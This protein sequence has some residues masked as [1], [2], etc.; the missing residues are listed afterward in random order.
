MSNNVTNYAYPILNEV[1]HR[2][3]GLVP[4]QERFKVLS[5]CFTP[6]KAAAA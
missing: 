1:T 2:L 4:V 5:E 3:L 6:E